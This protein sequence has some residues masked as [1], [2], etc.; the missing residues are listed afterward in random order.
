MEQEKK[1]DGASLRFRLAAFH[2]A[3]ALGRG[4]VSPI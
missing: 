1:T 2:E 4:G 3:L